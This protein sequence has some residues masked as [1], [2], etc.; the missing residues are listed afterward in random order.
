MIIRP[1]QGKMKK[2]TFASFTPL[3]F[4]NICNLTARCA[5]DA[6]HAKKDQNILL[7]PSKNKKQVYPL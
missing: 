7:I 5:Q 3:R 1:D 2:Q 4:K 6:K